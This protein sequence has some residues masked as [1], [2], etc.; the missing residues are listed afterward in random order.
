MPIW[1]KK[2]RVEVKRWVC[3]NGHSN[4]ESSVE[5]NTCTTTIRSNRVVAERI[6]L[7]DEEVKERQ[8]DQVT[9]PVKVEKLLPKCTI[10]GSTD[11]V[12]AK[13]WG[14][15]HE[16]RITTLVNDWET[17]FSLNAKTVKHFSKSEVTKRKGF[18]F[19]KD[20]QRAE[21][22]LTA[23]KTIAPFGKL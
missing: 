17:T 6:E 2:P 19:L 4:I 1:K 18:N 13:Y 8:K 16:E 9:T 7:T 11:V 21:R 14:K 23:H 12:P 3:I 20:L 22:V 15:N 10:C 5:C